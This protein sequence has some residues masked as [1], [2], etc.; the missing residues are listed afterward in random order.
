MRNPIFRVSN[1]TLRVLSL[2]AGVQSSTLYLMALAGEFE[3]RPDVA[4]FADTQWEPAGVYAWLNELERI[5][6]ATIP[7]RRVTKGNIRDM[8]T[9]KDLSYRAVSLPVFVRPPEGSTAPVGGMLHRQCTKE[10]KIEPLTK[11]TRRLLGVQRGARVPAGV[12]V[13]R[14][15]GISLDEATR[16]TDSRERW[17]TNRYPLVDRR[18]TRRDC[19]RWLDAHGYDAARV[20]KSAC[21]ACPYTNDA[22]WRDMKADRPDEF[23]DAVRFD[24]EI[25]T[26]L[27]GIRG[28]AFVHR[29][30]LPLADVDF[31]TDED[32][33]QINA[34]ENECEGMCGV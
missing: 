13:E 14:W 1:P 2:G 11:E 16:M 20:P 30:L 19:M 3:A 26:R 28:Q 9:R 8:A 18:M 17:C 27:P 33:G 31:R 12:H 29:S 25:R 7:I 15:I 21:I 34:F 32:M 6:G 4:I 10:F 23:A 5:G 22:R 24:G